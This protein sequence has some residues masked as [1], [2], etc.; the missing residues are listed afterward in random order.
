M[1]T[2]LLYILIGLAVVAIAF[3]WARLSLFRKLQ[4]IPVNQKFTNVYLEIKVPREEEKHPELVAAP[5]AAE[6]MF[7]SLHGLLKVTPESQEHLAFEIVSS[8]R[9][10]TFYVAVPPPVKPFVVSQIYAQYP[11]AQIREITDYTENFYAD[12]R[13]RVF[14]GAY[15]D[16]TKEYFFPIKTFRDFEVD[17]LSAI[18]S[19]L[20]EVDSEEEVCFQ[21]SVR[22]VPDVWQEEGRDYIDLVREG[23]SKVSL[24]FKDILG[25]VTAGFG[26]LV[27]NVIYRALNPA[28]E[29]E[30]GDS[31][32]VAVRLSSGQELEIKA[33]DEKL[34]RM[35]FQ[36]VIRILALAPT[37]EAAA[38]RIR[39]VTASFKQ[40]ST[41]HLNSFKTAESLVNDTG[42]LQDYRDRVFTDK[43]SFISTTEELA[44]IYHLPSSTVETPSIAWVPAKR[45]EPPLNLPTEKCT[46][47]GLTTFRDKNVKFGIKD[48]DRARHVYLVGK[49][50]TGKSTVFRNMAI[51]DMQ[52][53]KGIGVIDPHG[54]L[55]HQLLESVPD[56]RVDDV[57]Y[58]DP[59]DVNY[60]VGV[61]IFECPDPSQKNLMASG[62]LEVFKKHFGLISWGPRLEY[63]LNYSILTLIDVP[64]TTLLGVLRLLSDDNYRKYILHK[65]TDPLVREFWEK[66]FKGMKG[67]SSLIAEA[68]S[69]IQNKVGRFLS[70]S[71]IRN[72]LGQ[73][74]SSIDFKAAMDEGKILLVNL[75]KG[76]IGED[77]AN[78][79]GSLIVSRLSFMI[80]Q[81]VNV[82]EEERQPFFLYVDE[83][84]NIASGAFATVLSE[85]RKYNLCLHL[86]HQYT[87]QLPEEMMDAVFGNIGTLVAFTL[88][89]PDAKVLEPEFAPAMTEFDLIGLERYHVYV[90][91]MIDAMTSGP[92]SGVSL[93]PPDKSEFTGN[94][95]EAIRQSRQKYGRD[96]AEVEVKIKAWIER[97][98][99]LGMAIAEEHR[100]RRRE[101]EPAV[102][103]FAGGKE[104]SAAE[105][106]AGETGGGAAEKDPPATV[107]YQA[108][109]TNN[110][111]KRDETQL[112]A[113]E[114]SGELTL[115]PTK[116]SSD[117][118]E[119]AEKS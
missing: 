83:F 28:E 67:S 88:G 70:S 77:N 25:G 97:P 3:I 63:L 107:D 119:P 65:V 75:S 46:Y 26:G 109:Q 79:L 9:G 62:I 8:D 29:I 90:K 92:F 24:T 5:I 56:D 45:A 117:D 7:A 95:D 16:L 35:G 116:T 64:G 37:A 20:G 42:F 87:A 6:Q 99:D 57:I 96:V 114:L 54:E 81:R 30:S 21:L 48:I 22:P 1:S 89:A 34:T 69:P 78:L 12:N 118:Q 101:E 61:N 55:V 113:G 86:T 112:A 27:G 76:K 85:A 73:R 43:H 84:Q 4:R 58:F 17:P 94:K 49:T 115:G 82:P 40:F 74:T 53:G 52:N 105:A 66:E 106:V 60:P 19:A 23:Q 68:L 93:P 11:H 72:I 71:T 91:L 59:S 80:M 36:V 31:R 2:Y 32:P 13:D 14:Q 44:S 18:T 100:D 108:G 41:A 110:E 33:I 111:P 50:G 98:F 47:I 104:K 103:E 10:I 15:L 38:S 39:G 102:Q 51:Q